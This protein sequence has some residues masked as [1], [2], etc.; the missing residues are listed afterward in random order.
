MQALFW[1]MLFVP[2]AG[3]ITDEQLKKFMLNLNSSAATVPVSLKQGNMDYVWQTESKT[4]LIKQTDVTYS[5]K[6][7]GTTKLSC[8]YDDFKA[9]GTKMYPNLLIL[10]GKTQATQKPRDITVTIKM[11]GVKMDNDWETRTTLS[12]KYKEVSVDEVLEKIT[13]L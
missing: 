10:N 3:N 6:A 5:D 2:G 9:L 8:K 11:K 7:N 4:G 1:N 12:D 13:S